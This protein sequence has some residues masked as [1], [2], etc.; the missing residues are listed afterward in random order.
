MGSFATKTAA[1][2]YLA[3]FKRETQLQAIVAPSK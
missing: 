3:D 2:Q 1:Q